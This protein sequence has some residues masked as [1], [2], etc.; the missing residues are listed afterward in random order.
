M[1]IRGRISKTFKMG[2][3]PMAFYFIA[4]G[5][6]TYPLILRFATH[7]F[8]DQGDGLQNVWNIWWMNK[9]ITELHQS[10]W[11][12]NYLHY[13]YGVSLLGHTLNPFNGFMGIGLLKFLSLIETYNFI[14]I[15]SFVFAGLTAFWLAYHLTKSYWASV[16][17]GFI[18]T[19]SNYH[20]AH[21]EGH[22]NLVSLE[23]LPLFI[24]AWY[25]FLTRP[26]IT[27]AI[28]SALVL[29]LVFLC[30]YYYFFY[31]VLAGG[32]MMGWRIKRLSKYLI[33]FIVFS[34]IILAV[35]GPFITSLLRLDRN[36][37][38]WGSH[39][40]TINS[41]DLLAPFIPGG[42]WRLAGLTEFFWSNLPGNIHESSVHMG[43][44]VLSM[45][46]Y[47]WI[48][49]RELRVQGLRLWYFI[50]IF[51][52]IM[53]LGPVLHIWGTEIYFLR[54]P[55]ALGKEAFPSLKLSGYLVRALVMLAL[56]GI[57]FYVLNHLRTIRKQSQSRGQWVW[58][59]A[60]VFFAVMI[61][62][63]TLHIWGT[64]IF[65]LKMP[66][67]LLEKALPFLKLSG[68]PVRMMVMVM[69]SASVIWAMGFEILFKNS[70]R[71]RWL[72]A[73]WL[74]MVFFEYLPRPLPSSQIATPGYVKILKNL[75]GNDG[76]IDTVTPP[77]LAGYYQT[78]HQKPLA[79]SDISRIPGSVWEKDNRLR[80]LVQN[81]DYNTLYRD[82]NFRYLLTGAA[83][84][85]MA[86]KLLYQDT[87]VKLY[88]LGT[89]KK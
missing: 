68:N 82:Y 52:G 87:K 12:T 40:S 67:P 61:F 10:P 33:P 49:R 9:A 37:P 4:F 22:L 26:G 7:F 19:F 23:W 60:L 15:F 73:I 28:A 20:F 14:L 30:D 8:A 44:G 32:L 43:L 53:S 74:I 17:A 21:A 47:T 45:L 16:I 6:L 70:A 42:H 13:P 41:L 88:A 48:K 55:Y 59:A 31:S 65:F 36:D 34:S 66:Y 3:F 57:L 80:R 18:F 81:K 35:T 50:L 29:V 56:A 62:E 86:I 46:I 24:L 85:E 38:L 79:F 64:G 84:V 76:I 71:K 83:T 77:L 63:A 2:I 69:L 25:I 78:I 58:Y 72:A 75:P 1:K 51:F 54:L 11:Q 89:E 5:L 39:P 27:V